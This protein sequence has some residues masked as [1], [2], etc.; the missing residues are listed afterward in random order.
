MPR[1]YGEKIMKASVLISAC[2]LAAF[3]VSGLSAEPP[4]ARQQQQEKKELKS[5]EMDELIKAIHGELMELKKTQPWLKGYNDKCL[6]NKW[7]SYSPPVRDKSEMLPQQSSHISITYCPI[8][9]ERTVDDFKYS[10]HL[11]DVAACRFSKLK[12]K[13]YAEILVWNKN[14]K[15]TAEAIRKSI[16]KQCEAM[17]KKLKAKERAAKK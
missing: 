16:I 5:P 7:I 1:Q 4:P 13:I 2:A 8:D 11:E 15:V 10:N 6:H 17:Q 14:D 12:L 3:F 9:A